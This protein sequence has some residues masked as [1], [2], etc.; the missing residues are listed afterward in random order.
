MN[1]RERLGL[2]Y[3]CSSHYD[4]YFGNL[5]VSSGIDAA[6]VDSAKAEILAQLEAIKKG[7]IS[8]AEIHAAKKAFEHYCRQMYD[9]P[10]ELFTF[11]RSRAIIGVDITPEEHIRHISDVTLEDVIELARGIKLDT[12]FLLEGTLTPD[13]EQEDYDD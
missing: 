4:S 5:T 2:C 6:N 3:Y 8:N 9:Y 11:Y 7:E 12:V 13:N 1:V 10:S